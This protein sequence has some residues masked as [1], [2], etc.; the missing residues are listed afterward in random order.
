MKTK[1]DLMDFLLGGIIKLLLLSIIGVITFAVF[2]CNKPKHDESKIEP[3]YYDSIRIF[4]ENQQKI[5][6][7]T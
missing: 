6:Y 3:D 5:Y 2:S 1:F 7:T 4:R